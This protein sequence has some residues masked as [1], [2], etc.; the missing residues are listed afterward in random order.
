MAGAQLIHCSRC[1]RD[2]DPAAFAPSARRPGGW[3]RD[4]RRTYQIEYRRVVR[5]LA[6]RPRRT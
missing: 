6:S 4:C 5:M 3:C 1:G 2:R